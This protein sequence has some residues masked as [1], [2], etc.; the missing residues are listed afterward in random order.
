MDACG[1]L[2]CKYRDGPGVSE[3]YEQARSLF[4]K[5]CNGGDQVS[6]QNL[7]AL[8]TMGMA[9][10]WHRDFRRAFIVYQKSCV[11][12]YMGSC[13][14]LAYFYANGVGGV[15]RDTAKAL[16]L[17]NKACDAGDKGACINLGTF[18]NRP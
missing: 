17:Y 10:D 11:E 3:N 8:Y 18:V 13:T 1:V 4:E 2:A 16:A 5:A 6:C 9:P 12:G 7:G 14:G 15:A